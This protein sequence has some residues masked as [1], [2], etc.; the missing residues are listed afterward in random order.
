MRQLLPEPVDPIAVSD[1]WRPEPRHIDRRPWV[2]SLMVSSADGA[3]VVD[4]RSGSLGGEGDRAVFRAVRALADVIVVGAG[5]V[6]AEDY[7]PPQPSAAIQAARVERGQAARPRLVIVSGRLDLDP[8]ARVF[9][10]AEADSDTPLLAHPP[11]A[12]ADARRRL[13][14]H[15]ELVEIPAADDGSVSAPALLGE[16]GQRGVEVAVC[17]GGPTLNGALVAADLVD[18]MSLTLDP[19]VVGGSSPRTVSGDGAPTLRPWRTVALLEHDGALL[20]RLARDRGV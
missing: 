18:E 19:A 8:G 16:L 5:T 12:P 3:A 9:A 7:G 4:G 17:E 14:G 13:A 6:R 1:V 2:I 10:G 11:T 15:A 20:W